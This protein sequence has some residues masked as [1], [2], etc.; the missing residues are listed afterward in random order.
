MYLSIKTFDVALTPQLPSD[1]VDDGK[2]EK[3]YGCYKE[4]WRSRSGTLSVRGKGELWE[5]G[6]IGGDAGT[7]LLRGHLR[8]LRNL[9]PVSAKF[10]FW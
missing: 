4:I 10:Y 1:H 8:L 6:K 3:K 7:C 5:T 9:Q 2:D